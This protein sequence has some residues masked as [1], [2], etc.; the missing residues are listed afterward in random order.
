[1]A[2]GP[3]KSLEGYDDLLSDLKER[4]RRAQT[5]A[6]LSVNSEMM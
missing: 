2:K 6:M 4:I 3:S 5:R 1:M